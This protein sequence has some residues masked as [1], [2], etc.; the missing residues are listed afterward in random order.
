[1]IGRA[2]EDVRGLGMHRSIALQVTLGSS[3]LMIMGANLVYPVLPV[4]AQSLAVPEG[5]IGLVLT[6][7]TLPAVFLAP[8]TGALTDLRGR[9]VVLVGGLL[10]YGVAGLSIALVDTLPWLLALRVAQGVGYA[11]VMPLVVV[12]IGDAFPDPRQQ[13]TA[14]G[15]KV[16]FDR[17]TLLALPAAVGVLGGIAWQWP[18]VIYGAAIPLALAAVRWL[19]EPAM[20]ARTNAPRY[21]KEVAQAA[22]RVRSLVIFSMSSLRFFIE[23]SFFIYV[24]LFA[25]NVLGVSVVRGGLL[26][27]VFAIG[28]IATAGAVGPLAARFERMPLVVGAFVVQAAALLGASVAPNVWVLGLAMLVFGLANGVISPV[29]KSLLTLSVPLELRGGYVSADRLAQSVAKSIAPLVAGGVVALAGIAVMFQVIAGVAGA[30]A[31]GVIVLDRLGL[32]R[33]GVAGGTG[34]TAPLPGPFAD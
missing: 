26:F 12:L 25:L 5:Q 17:M 10:I 3:V 14:Q 20:E 7:F 11:A 18:F 21:L 1:M 30:W 28:S 31:L 29:Q 9:R 19:P 6:A 22:V 34:A 32:L 4:I 16:V 15:V 8:V 24:P 2:V 33:S 13:T 23:L 27:T